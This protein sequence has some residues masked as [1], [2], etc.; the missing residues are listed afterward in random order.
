MSCGHIDRV[1]PQWRT[2]VGYGVVRGWVLVSVGAHELIVSC[3]RHVC[4]CGTDLG[5]AL[6]WRDWQ[7]DLTWFITVAVGIVINCLFGWRMRQGAVEGFRDRKLAALSFLSMA[8]GHAVACVV[9]CLL[10]VLFVAS[11][12]GTD[13]SLGVNCALKCRVAVCG[14]WLGLLVAGMPKW[15]RSVTALRL[16]RSLHRPACRVRPRSRQ[17][18]PMREGFYR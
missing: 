18:K 17:A 16:Q 11:L 1:A 14:L 3:A 7:F 9:E 4:L 8:A 5:S 15:H 10:A 13:E 6:S 12:H 2:A